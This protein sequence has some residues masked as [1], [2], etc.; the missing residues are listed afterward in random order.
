[1]LNGHDG[2]A[3]LVDFGLHREL[4]ARE[5]R[6]RAARRGTSALRVVTGGGPRSL[7]PSNVAWVCCC[8]GGKTSALRLAP[9]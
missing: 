9:R 3:L 5:R 1:M 6:A 8:W 4:D 2:R 7:Q